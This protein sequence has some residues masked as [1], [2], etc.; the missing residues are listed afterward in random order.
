MNTILY[1]AAD[2]AGTE[3]LARALA[4]TL[5][6]G[7]VIA[8][9]GTL[10][11]GKTRLVQAIAATVGVERRAVVSPTYVLVQEYAGSKPIYHFDLYRLRD[12]DEFLELAPDEYFARGGWT[13]LEWASKF[14]RCLPAE[15]LDITIDVLGETSRRFTLTAH[16]AAYARVM[17]A[18]AEKS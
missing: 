8:L 4:A 17:E 12:E 13:F 9:N 11:A 2:E 16:G 5:P 15:R 10:G 1:E 6:A 14:P 7:A 3:R 18:V